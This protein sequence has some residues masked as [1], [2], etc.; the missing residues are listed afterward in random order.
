MIQGSARQD[1]TSGV[2]V[3]IMLKNDQR[4]GRLTKRI[5]LWL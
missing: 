2:K 4:N 1:I 3:E 5:N